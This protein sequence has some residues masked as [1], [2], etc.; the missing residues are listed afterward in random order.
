MIAGLSSIQICA[1]IFVF[2]LGYALE[3]KLPW[4]S[5]ISRTRQ[6]F[7]DVIFDSVFANVFHLCVESGMVSGHSQVIDAAPI[8]ANA[9]MDSLELKVPP[10]ELSD[11]LRKVRYMSTPDRQ[12]RKSKKDKSSLD[13]RSITANDQQLN[14]IKSRN[15]KWKKD[16]DER[17]GS[18]H[19]LAKYTSNKTHYSPS[20]PDARIS[21]KPGK[22]RKLNYS[23]QM[24]VDTAHHVITHIG[25]AFADKKDSQC[26]QDVT[27]KLKERLQKEGLIWE[28]ILAD[29]GYSSGENYAF[30][31]GLG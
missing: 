2:F 23:C 20:D 24:G 29:T 31:E 3:E 8:K 21:V 25:A 1:W 22:S 30:L 4:H 15:I 28:S 9:S 12:S 18:K 19:N 27:F 11:H 5:T 16:Q 10:E 7:P 6:L 14:G 13:Q 26:L 17:P